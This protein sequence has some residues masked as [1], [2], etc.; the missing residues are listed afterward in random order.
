MS[1]RP[2]YWSEAAP[3][4]EEGKGDASPGVFYLICRTGDVEY[5][6]AMTPHCA[7]R[8]G[9]SAKT[10]VDAFYRR[11]ATVLDFPGA[12]RAADRR[13]RKGRAKP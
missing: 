1:E 12:P 10:A 8:L 3:T 13:K 11:E 9:W 7:C 2:I 6:F 4:V 5:R